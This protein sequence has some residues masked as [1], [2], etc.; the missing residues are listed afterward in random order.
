VSEAGGARDESQRHQAM[1]VH[2][3]MKESGN[4]NFFV[5]KT[6]FGFQAKRVLINFIYIF[7]SKNLNLSV[8]V[9]RLTRQYFMCQFQSL[10]FGMEPLFKYSLVCKGMFK[11]SWRFKGLKGFGKA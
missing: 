8:R 5:V 1:D 4:Y 6:C 7:K 3:V 9:F 2:S 11:I 10:K